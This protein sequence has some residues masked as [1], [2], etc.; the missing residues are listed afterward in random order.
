MERLVKNVKECSAADGAADGA[1]LPS[2]S[3]GGAGVGSVT[4]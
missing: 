2:H 3:R 1:H 4:F